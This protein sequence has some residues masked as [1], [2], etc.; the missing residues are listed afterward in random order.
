MPEGHCKACNRL[1]YDTEK[2]DELRDEMECQHCHF[3]NTI[4]EKVVEVAIVP[5]ARGRRRAR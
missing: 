2:L 3:T 5:K 1:I 4:R